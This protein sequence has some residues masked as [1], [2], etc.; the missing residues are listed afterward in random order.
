MCDLALGS[1]YEPTREACRVW[2]QHAT[3]LPPD[4]AEAVVVFLW[5]PILTVRNMRKVLKRVL[6]MVCHCA[7]NDLLGRPT[8]AQLSRNQGLA[9]RLFMVTVRNQHFAGADAVQHRNTLADLGLTLRPVRLCYDAHV[10]P[11]LLATLSNPVNP[12]SFDEVWFG[13]YRPISM[14]ADPLACLFLEALD[15]S[16]GFGLTIV[17]DPSRL[18]ERCSKLVQGVESNEWSK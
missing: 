2:V 5:D 15:R 12:V 7:R 6:P 16:P 1:R 10:G 13:I 3:H 8:W 4:L 18:R 9:A 11:D 14:D 17:I